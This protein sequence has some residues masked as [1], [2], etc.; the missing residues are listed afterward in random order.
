M[1][2]KYKL[3]IPLEHNKHNSKKNSKVISFYIKKGKGAESKGIRDG[4]RRMKMIEVLY[5]YVW[6]YCYRSEEGR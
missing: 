5:M 2:R 1:K 6:K 3:P 4:N